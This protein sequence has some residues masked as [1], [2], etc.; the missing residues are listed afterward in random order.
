MKIADLSP[1]L[2]EQ[3]KTVRWDRIIEKHEGPEVWEYELGF[4]SQYIEL[5][6]ADDAEFL[7]IEGRFV[8]LPIARKRHPNLTILRTIP[9]ADGN[10]LTLFI[11][12]TTYGDSMFESGYVAVCEKVA[13]QVAPEGFFLATL[14]HEWFIIEP[15]PLFA[16]YPAQAS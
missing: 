9:S 6:E 2:L 1:E 7:E 4:R 15:N 13:P 12:D 14:Y 10:S 3:L 8:L 16:T 11:K 5:T